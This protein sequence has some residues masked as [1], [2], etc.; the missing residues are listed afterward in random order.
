M[1]LYKNTKIKV[2]SADGDTNYFNIVTGVLQED[3]LAPYLF[4]ICLD[5]VLRPSI[6]LMKENSFK[7]SKERSR[8]YPTHNI[9]D[10]DYTNDTAFLANTPA[11][12]ESLLHTLEQ[13]A[14]GI[15]LHVNTD[16]T[17]YMC[18]N[19]RGDISTQKGGPLKLVDK[20][21]YL[22]SS[23]LSTKNDI[24]TQLAK[25]WTAIDYILLSS[26][27]NKT[28]AFLFF[29]GFWQNQCFRKYTCYILFKW[30]IKISQIMSLSKKLVFFQII[31]N[32]LQLTKLVPSFLRNIQERKNILFISL[33]IKVFVYN[34][35]SKLT[36]EDIKH[37]KFA[38]Q[39]KEES[40]WKVVFFF[41]KEFSYPFWNK[42]HIKY[43]LVYIKAI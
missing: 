32:Y 17:E 33:S 29:F 3:T 34:K 39:R 18:F 26:N 36:S 5:D 25:A 11:Q 31:L 30:K 19:Q 16:K 2:R 40:E 10:A 23:V 9:M 35:K 28:A 1:M 8:S 14:G 13:A 37:K 22:G 41:N 7:L 43:F 24:N 20:F 15:G 6:D 12:A 4:I 27:I 38:W 42:S 21:T